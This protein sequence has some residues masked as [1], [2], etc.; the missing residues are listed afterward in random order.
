MVFAIGI[1]LDLLTLRLVGI[2]S[3]LFLLFSWAIVRYSQKIQLKNFLFVSVLL[4]I[5]TDFYSLLFY[6][7]WFSAAEIAVTLLLS[8]ILLITIPKI[9]PEKIGSKDKLLL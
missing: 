7:R 9:F 4:L 5:I 6:G 3:L 2:D 1:V 8:Y